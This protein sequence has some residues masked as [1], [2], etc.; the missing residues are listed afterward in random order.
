MKNFI[1][2]V[3]IFG[4]GNWVLP[5]HNYIEMLLTAFA[6]KCYDKRFIG[7]ISNCFA[8]YFKNSDTVT[9]VAYSYLLFFHEQVKALSLIIILFY[10][11]MLRRFPMIFKY[12]NETSKLVEETRQQIMPTKNVIAM[13]LQSLGENANTELQNTEDD[14]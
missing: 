11:R 9:C 1:Y 8:K 2:C 14:S 13:L 5:P 12:R 3:V 6:K 10:I 7:N 4:K